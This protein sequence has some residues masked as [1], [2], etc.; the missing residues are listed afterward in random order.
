M[1]VDAPLQGW[2]TNCSAASCGGLHVSNAAADRLPSSK[3]QSSPTS[4]HALLGVVPTRCRKALRMLGPHE[5][6]LI[7]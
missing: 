4:G 7:A 2:Q 6:P 3:C 5:P 1:E